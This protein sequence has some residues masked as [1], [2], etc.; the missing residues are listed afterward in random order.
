[1]NLARVIAVVLFFVALGAEAQYTS[2]GLTW[3]DGIEPGTASVCDAPGGKTCYWVDCDAGSDGTGTYASPY[4]GFETVYGYYSGGSYFPG[5]AVGGDI[6]YVKGTCAVSESV[7]T[8]TGPLRQA[9]VARN[10]QVGTV[11]EPSILKSYKGEA[12]AIFDG[13]F[14]DSITGVVDANNNPLLG[15]IRIH[16]TI[17]TVAKGFRVENVK[18]TRARRTGLNCGYSAATVAYCDIHSVWFEDNDID[19]NGVY[20]PLMIDGSAT[21]YVQAH[22][23]R[24]NRFTNNYRNCSADEANMSGDVTCTAGDNDGAIGVYSANGS[25]PIGTI[26]I[27]DNYFDN[28]TKHIRDKHNG[29]ITKTV[30]NNWF[31][32]SEGEA[33]YDRQTAWTVRHNIFDM[34]AGAQYLMVVTDDAPPATKS[35][36]LNF[37]NNSIYN[38]SRMIDIQPGAGTYT[39]YL[40]WDVYNNAVQATSATDRYIVI[41]PESGTTATFTTAKWTSNNN[42]FNVGATTQTKFTYLG[43]ASSGSGGTERDFATSMT[44]L[45]D[46]SSSVTNPLFEDPAGDDFCLQAGASSRTAGES[47]GYLGAIDPT[48]CGGSSSTFRKGT[49]GGSAR[50]GQVG[51]ARKGQAGNTFKGQN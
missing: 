25:V 38:A 40:T 50:K 14:D 2:A 18:I 11:A 43:P 8:A 30:Y 29:S 37:Y 32:S 35:R 44:Y 42:Y 34:G 28:N 45:S 36:S 41:H 39:D 27:Y 23:I 10:A 24:N 15:L 48:T 13:E 7:D 1:M 3:P 4:W 17:V 6:V 21:D 19:S 51:N 9:I 22:T 46:A 12:Q 20:G 16:P 47:G 26:D 31:G 5:T 49:N 33:L